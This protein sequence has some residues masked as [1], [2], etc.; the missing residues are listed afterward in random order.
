MARAT[1]YLN[2]EVV[3]VRKTDRIQWHV[4]AVGYALMGFMCLGVFLLSVV[5]KPLRAGMRS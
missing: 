2:E 1:P 5:G 3:P 4:R